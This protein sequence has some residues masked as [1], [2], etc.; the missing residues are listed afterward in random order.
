MVEIENPD[1]TRVPAAGALIEVYRTD[2]KA[3]LPSNKTDK[4]GSFAFAGL[5]YNGTFTFAVS[6]PGASPT[7]FPNVKA[8]QEKLVI[9]LHPG[10]G[11]KLTEADARK[12][13]AI[14]ANPTA[15]AELSAE[16]KKARADYEKQA[17]D[18]AAK[19]ERNQKSG[20]IAQSSLKAG[21]EAFT[22]KNYDV[23]IAKYTEGVDAQPD[24]VGSAPVLLSN[25]G[26]AYDARAIKVYNEFAKS[27][28]PAAKADAYGKT[29]SD[30]KEAIASYQAAW[31][32][33]QTAPAADITN[34]QQNEANK[35]MTLRG[36]RDAFK[37]A[38]LTEQVDPAMIEAATTLLTEYEKAE[39]DA[40]KKVEA[41]LILGDLYRVSQEREKSIE[42]Y[43]KVL[44]TQPD[45]VDALAGA[46]LV[47]VDLSWLK[48]NDK[49]MAQEGAN[50][51][52]KFVSL[53]PDTH[54]LKEGAKGY[55]DILKTQS[56]V[57]VKGATKKKP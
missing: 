43:K 13:T 41:G 29:K 18:V 26:A 7:I 40:A 19:N 11:H 5:P 37:H 42:A 53:A 47:L 12:G 17:A 55:L 56:I 20:E 21:N 25:R 48:D 23:A 51:L 57:P 45:N 36:A 33:Y 30:L 35:L 10:D 6:A 46:G 24:F 54:K 27:P 32:I 8:G 9:T 2:I 4:K 50:Y 44:E 31:K 38:S 52:Q 14:M 49:A 22:S 16:D 15:S 1:G 39:T 28:D 3:S 34:P